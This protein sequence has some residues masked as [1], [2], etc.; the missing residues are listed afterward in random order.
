MIRVLCSSASSAAD[1]GIL[2]HSDYI[3][4]FEKNNAK[5]L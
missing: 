3:A 5:K 1:A 2:P 4:G